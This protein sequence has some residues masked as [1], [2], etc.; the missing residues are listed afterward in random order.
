MQHSDVIVVGGGIVGATA[1]NAFA[2]SGLQVSLVEA[3]EPLPAAQA[4]PDPRV[5]AIT[6]ASERIFRSLGV[7]DEKLH[8]NMP[9]PSPTWRSG[10]PAVT[11]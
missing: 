3:R 7:W 6:R 9:A 8:R 1:A 4:K 10:M 5:F 2:Q 11:A